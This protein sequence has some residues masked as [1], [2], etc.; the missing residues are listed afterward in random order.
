MS[1]VKGELG[2]RKSLT[3]SS[4]R[5]SLFGLLWILVALRGLHIY[6]P[7][8]K[9]RLLH[10]RT[11]GFF[12]GACGPLKITYGIRFHS[13]ADDGVTVIE[14]FFDYTLNFDLLYSCFRVSE[15][16]CIVAHL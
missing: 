9:P 4:D 2:L 14:Q 1:S 3:S 12:A 6:N 10:A 15:P 16:L 7:V 13:V 8:K 11:T 5:Q